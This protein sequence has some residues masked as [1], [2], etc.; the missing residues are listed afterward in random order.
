M[1]PNRAKAEENDGI[2]PSQGVAL[3]WT[4]TL[5]PRLLLQTAAL[6]HSRAISMND[7]NPSEDS[8]R[9]RI[10]KAS[11]KLKLGFISSDFRSHAMGQ[12]VIGILELLDRSHFEVFGYLSKVRDDPVASRCKASLD[13]VRPIE[14]LTDEEALALIG[15]DDISILFNLN[16]D[17]DGSRLGIM[18]KRPSP[19]QVSL[20]G[21]SKTSGTDVAHMYLY[22]DRAA[23]PPDTLTAELQAER[24]VLM[25]HSY[26][27]SSHLIGGNIRL[28]MDNKKEKNHPNMALDS[29][30]DVS[31]AWRL[32]EKK[33]VIGSLNRSK[34]IDP[35]ILRCWVQT[36]KRILQNIKMILALFAKPVQAGDSLMMEAS[37]LGLLKTSVRLFEQ[38]SPSEYLARISRVDLALDTRVW[39]GEMTTLD[40]LYEATP[41]ITIQGNQMSNRFG[42]SSA[43]ALGI[44]DTGTSV[45]TLKEYEDQAVALASGL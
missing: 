39:N 7:M 43:Q 8:F 1:A 27:L 34:K 42:I 20:I 15:V 22:S 19:I 5:N 12:V 25:P 45:A 29:F 35:L 33:I 17:T 4:M 14:I 31:L 6:T 24:A 30:D 32:Q 3:T 41:L 38:A 10:Q 2:W 44:G 40:V 37:A 23:S 9:N 16:G 21:D 13:V 18:L 36:S 26:H 11:N 28:T